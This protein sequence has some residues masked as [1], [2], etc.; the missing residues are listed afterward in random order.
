MTNPDLSTVLTQR[1]LNFK[2]QL[3]MRS[4][5]Q[6]QVPQPPQSAP[7]APSDQLRGAAPVPQNGQP[8]ANQVPEAK[9]E[10]THSRSP[11]SVPVNH[12]YSAQPVPQFISTKHMLLSNDSRVQQ[13]QQPQQQQPLED[14]SAS[15]QAPSVSCLWE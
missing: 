7:L 11:V 2:R 6:H 8:H 3:E 12:I 1:L 4:K 13:R 15:V 14:I 9:V 10:D 5:M